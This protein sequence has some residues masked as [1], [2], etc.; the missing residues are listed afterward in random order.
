MW[1]F[2][3]KH[4]KDHLQARWHNSNIGYNFQ[5]YPAKFTVTKDS[6]RIVA[7]FL[8]LFGSSYIISMNRSLRHTSRKKH[9]IVVIELRH[10][11]RKRD[12]MHIS[13]ITNKLNSSVYLQVKLHSTDVFLHCRA[14]E[15]KCR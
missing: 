10:S 3:D 13:K 4:G 9:H 8:Q 15:H 2:S 7:R 1:C 11:S 12:C 6:Y 5:T 14:F